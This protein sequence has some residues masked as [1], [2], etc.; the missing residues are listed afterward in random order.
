VEAL[1]RHGADLNQVVGATP[2]HMAVDVLRRGVAGKPGAGTAAFAAAARNAQAGRDP[3]IAAPNGTTS[4][5]TVVEKGYDVDGT[6]RQIA[7][8]KKDKRYFTALPR[9]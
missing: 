8:R 1:L 2:F 7:S 4:L 3:N 9:R 6:V 5:H